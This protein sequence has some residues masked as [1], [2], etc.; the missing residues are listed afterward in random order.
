MD[1]RNFVIGSAAAGTALFALPARAQ[2]AYPT[3][4][5]TIVNLSLPSAH[6]G[7]R[8]GQRWF[9]SPP[10]RVT[11]VTPAGNALVSTWRTRPDR[12]PSRNEMCTQNH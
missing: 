4:A 12:A 10:A 5:I 8:I 3:R 7:R 2:E 1:R 9:R 6:R 11:A